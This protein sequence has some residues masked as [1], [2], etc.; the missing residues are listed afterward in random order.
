MTRSSGARI[1][2][3]RRGSILVISAAS[4][5]VLLGVGALAI[6]LSYLLEIRAELQNS[7]DAVALAAASGL[8]VGQPEA[9]RRAQQYAGLNPI[10]KQPLTVNPSDLTFG[11]WDFLTNRFL[12]TTV[13]PNAVRVKVALRDTANSRQLFLAPVLGI[14]QADVS[15]VATASL[16]HRNLMLVLDRSGSMN[17]VS[18]NPEQPMSDMKTA[19]QRFL[20]LIQNFPIQGDLAG[21]VYYNEVAQLNQ[22]LTSNF[23]QVQNAIMPPTASGH[24]N[25]AAGLC[26]ARRELN[27]TRASRQGLKVVVLLSDGVTN[28]R[29]NSNCSISGAPGVDFFAGPGSISEQ[30]AL[31]QAKALAQAG[32]VLYTVSLGAATN[33]QLMNTMAVV[34]GGEHFYAPTTAQ[35]DGVFDQVSA[36]IPVVLVQ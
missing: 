26:V 31:A 25:I 32:F 20:S 17:D 23:N 19:A 30:Q 7:A 34:T 2:R 10:L 12:P 24:T 3:R 18:L 9:R 22:A 11:Q 6:D 27:S 14:N 8:T 16:S 21:L 33:Q 15:A 35:L 13:A 36:R 1:S 5:T 28:T 4:M 29:I